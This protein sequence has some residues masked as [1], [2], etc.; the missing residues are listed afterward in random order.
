VRGWILC[1]RQSNRKKGKGNYTQRNV[2][3]PQ[4]GRINNLRFGFQAPSQ[5]TMMRYHDHLNPTLAIGT[6][7]YYTFRV[8]SIWDTDQTGIGRNPL[9]YAQ[10]AMMYS[11][12]RVTR[13]NFVVECIPS[14]KP[15]YI[16]SFM[17]NGPYVVGTAPADYDRSCQNAFTKPGMLSGDSGTTYNH[18]R[19]MNLWNLCGVSQTS[20]LVD[21]RYASQINNNPLELV[22]LVIVAFCP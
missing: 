20:Y 9:G 6:T 16:N 2:G 12:Y 7:Y 19:T 11:R 13:A 18:T 5:E 1:R 3:L 10:M 21:D 17:I 4:V 15:F 8:N 22:Q 14:T